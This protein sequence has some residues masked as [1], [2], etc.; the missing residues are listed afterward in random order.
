MR[1]VELRLAGTFRVVRDGIELTDGEIGS[2]KSRILL[3]LLAVERP[4]L[5]PLDRIVD[6]LWPGERPAAPE[7]NVATLVSRLRAAL[8]ADL[9]QGGRAG[10]R[11]AA[12]PGI[13]VDLDA[14]ARFCD[15]AEGKLATAAAVALAAAERAHELL[16]AGTAIG[17]EPYADWADPARE[18]VRELLRRVRLV[19]AEAALAT[20]DPR[21]AA[22]YAEA[23]MAAD[24]L[25][26][27]AHRWYMSASVAAGEQAKALAAYEDAPA[28]A[29]P[30]A[31]RRPGTADAGAASG[32]PARAGRR[33]RTPAAGPGGAVRRADRRWQESTGRANA[34]RDQHQDG[35][36]LAGRD[37]EMGCCGRRGTR[38]WRSARAR[39]DRWRGGDREDRAGRVPRRRGGRKWRDG[40]A[41]PLL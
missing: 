2:R 5:V 3:K 31:W 8:G 38:P 35:T 39:H 32:D 6:V 9:I 34:G 20:G 37:A 18:Q 13:V 30:R 12:G 10:Y 4:G 15:Q 25:D 40:A 27:A 26:E 41:D 24:P 29:R 19:A 23:A 36:G 33:P 11:L 17:D 16:S 1:L 28:A 14:A 21:R 22:G 7:Q